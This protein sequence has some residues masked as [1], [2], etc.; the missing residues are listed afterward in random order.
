MRIA[1]D[2]YTPAPGRIICHIQRCRRSNLCT[3]RDPRWIIA[4]VFRGR[5]G[6]QAIRVAWCEG[7]FN[8]AAGG[9]GYYRGTF[10]VSAQWRRDAPGYGPGLWAQARHARRVN[11]R[12]GGHWRPWQCRPG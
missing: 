3:L 8:T 11:G 7:R 1:G 10:Q 5:L 12:T 2:H 4:Q 6:R 9:R